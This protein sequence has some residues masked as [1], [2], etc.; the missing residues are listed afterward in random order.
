MTNKIAVVLPCYKT[1]RHVLDVIARIGPDVFLI[2]VVDDACPMATGA[3]V[4]EHC[5]DPRV[6]VVTN[7]NN[8]GVGGATIAGYRFARNQ[9]ADIVV[10]IDS[11]GQMDPSLLPQLVHPIEARL[12]DYSKGNRF[13]S[14]EDVHTMPAIRV[15]GNVGL[16]FFTKLSTGYWNVFD[17]T[18]GYTA[19]H[20]VALDMLPLDKIDRRFFFSPTCCFG[21]TS[22]ARSYSTCQSVRP[23]QAKKATS[24]SDG[25][26]CRSYSRTS[27][28]ASSGYSIAIFYGT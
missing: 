16:S 14:I 3:H 17:P 10:K 18:N 27:G 13:F 21:F 1:K 15:F 26:C 2:V 25:S 22:P 11:D 5:S 7:E 6:V 19:I 4:R 8:L 24:A 23:T 28:I 12:A 20:R 9:A